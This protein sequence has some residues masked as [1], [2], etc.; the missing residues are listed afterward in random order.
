[1]AQMMM[2][3]GGGSTDALFIELIKQQE[4]LMIDGVIKGIYSDVNEL[5]ADFESWIN[6]E[7]DEMNQYKSQIQSNLSEALQG[8]A[9]EAAKNYLGHTMGKLKFGNPIKA[10]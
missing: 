9:G 8:K 10:V 6:A 4:R 2:N 3:D 7:E 5:R 1:M